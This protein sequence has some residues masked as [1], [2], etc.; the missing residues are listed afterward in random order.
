MSKYEPLRAHLAALTGD[1]WST[2][3]DEIE[4]LLGFR[5]PDS[6]R[7][8][9]PWWSNTVK[10][11]AGSV[12][13]RLAGFLTGDVKL[14]KEKVVFRRAGGAD[15]GVS[16]RPIRQ[17]RRMTAAEQGPV[18]D[19]RLK[20]AW[21]VLGQVC[22]DDRGHLLFPSPG[23]QPGIYRF[24]IT[25]AGAVRKYV[26]EAVNLARRFRN[27]R[28]PGPSQYTSIRLNGLLVSAL[29]A[30]AVIE[31]SVVLPEQAWVDIDGVWKR[32]NFESK[33]ERLLFESA[34]IIRGDGD[35]VEILNGAAEKR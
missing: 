29:A 1:E 5:L 27:Y 6:A 34:A 4:Q 2:T 33:A 26:G 23:I 28:R 11:S 14:D 15:R 20:M 18:E 3:F 31:V 35:D 17:P 30:G 16:R 21:S 8:H 25:Q 22:L 24:V 12:A 9:R 19:I 10:G 32:A 13:W 7:H